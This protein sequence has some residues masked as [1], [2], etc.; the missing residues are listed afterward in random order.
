MDSRFSLSSETS[1][2]TLTA[3]EAGIVLRRF[4]GSVVAPVRVVE[5]SG[6]VRDVIVL[7]LALVEGLA[8]IRRLVGEAIAVRL[9]AFFSSWPRDVLPSEVLVVVIGI[10]LAVDVRSA[11]VDGASDIRFGF[12]P[13]PVVFFSSLDLASTELV[14]V[15]L[16]CDVDGVV[17]MEDEDGLAGGLLRVLVFSAVEVVGLERVENLGATGFVSGFFAV[18]GLAPLSMVEGGKPKTER[19]EERKKP[20]RRDCLIWASLT[21]LRPTVDARNH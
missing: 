15:C 18:V 20:E 7:G 1:A 5:V 11:V 13:S 2:P 8:G 16:T 21:S 14:D 19:G 4:F 6:L 10:D 9:E 12:A 17:L 3:G